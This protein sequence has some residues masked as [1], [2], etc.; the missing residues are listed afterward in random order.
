MF[1]IFVSHQVAIS[2]VVAAAQGA[3]ILIFVVPHQFVKSICRQLKGAIKP[4]AMA[5][6]LIKVCVCVCPAG[7]W[8]TSLIH[9]EGPT[10]ILKPDLWSITVN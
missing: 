7:P 6:S 2:D 10:S 5:I 9:C 8:S 4:E 1:C 3:D